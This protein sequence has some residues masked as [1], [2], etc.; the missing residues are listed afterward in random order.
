MTSSESL[1]ALTSSAIDV[2][3]VLVGVNFVLVGVAVVGVAVVGVAVVGV[4]VVGVLDVVC[5]LVGD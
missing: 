3:G 2:I 4:N 5:V 1:S